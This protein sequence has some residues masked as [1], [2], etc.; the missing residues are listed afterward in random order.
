MVGDAAGIEPATGGGIH[1]A[2]SYGNIAANS[3]V[4]GFKNDDFSFNDY[5]NCF[6]NDLTGKYIDKLLSLA[7]KMY[8]QSINPIDAM[9]KIFIK[10]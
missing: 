5:N 1:L 3:I 8:D 4:N 10:R 6:K 9:K 7:Y 2:L